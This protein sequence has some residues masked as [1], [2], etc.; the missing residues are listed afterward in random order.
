MRTRSSLESLERAMLNG[1]RN[2]EWE[3]L[4]IILRDTMFNA[5]YKKRLIQDVLSI[6]QMTVCKVCVIIRHVVV[7]KI[8]DHFLRFGWTLM[9]PKESHEDILI[10]Q[11][12]GICST[13][14]PNHKA[15]GITQSTKWIFMGGKRLIISMCLTNQRKEQIILL[16]VNIRQ[17][18]VIQLISPKQI[19]VRAGMESL[20]VNSLIS[21]PTQTIWKL[22]AS[23]TTPLSWR[24]QKLLKELAS[25]ILWLS[26]RAINHSKKKSKD[27]SATKKIT[28][29]A[30]LPIQLSL[31]AEI[32]Y[33][34]YLRSRIPI[35]TQPLQRRTIWA[36]TLN[37]VI[38]GGKHLDMEERKKK[39]TNGLRLRLSQI[40]GPLL[41]THVNNSKLL[42]L[43]LMSWNIGLSLWEM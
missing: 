26:T 6:I 34:A 7:G 43:C 15:I 42:R 4:L 32:K 13:I 12:I 23:I 31:T 3:G 9:T 37:P 8:G 38:I 2:S 14:T 21:M 29:G 40:H 22:L 17:I 33:L 39:V 30:V 1:K 10:L 18:Q 5:D 19:N 20:G 35:P 41:S 28:H 27:T 25:K 11:F 36:C 16:Y 24:P